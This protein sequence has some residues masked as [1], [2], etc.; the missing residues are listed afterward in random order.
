MTSSI[1][2]ILKNARKEKK[3]SLSDIEKETKIR[4]KYLLAIENN[5]WSQ[6]TSRTYVLGIILAYGSFVGLNKEKLK[7]IFRREYEKT[8]IPQFKK[9]IPEGF[10]IPRAQKYVSSVIIILFAIFIAYF[11]LQ[12]RN[13][14][15]SPQVTIIS[16]KSNFVAKNILKIDLVGKTEKDSIIYINGERIYPDTNNIFRSKIPLPNKKNVITIEVTGANGRK[17]TITKIIQKK[18]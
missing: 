18:S 10:F 4:K 8:D 12:I 7:A 14:F 6:F 11:G 1:G 15:K 2:E 9:R 16:P 17:T 13:Y 3:I 5:D